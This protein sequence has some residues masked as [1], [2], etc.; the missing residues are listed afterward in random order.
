MMPQKK[1]ISHGPTPVSL[2]CLQLY[3]CVQNISWSPINPV[4][5]GCL[6]PIF[7]YAWNVRGQKDF[8]H[9]DATA[10]MQKLSFSEWLEFETPANGLPACWPL[11]PW[12]LG[13][14]AEQKQGKQDIWNVLIVCSLNM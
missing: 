2:I 12:D 10:I 11:A 1:N 14:R 13:Q 3:V 4:Q 8:L 5:P 7:L 9:K 6:E